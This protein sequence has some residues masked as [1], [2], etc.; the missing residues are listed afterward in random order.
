MAH[1]QEV[2]ALVYGQRAQAADLI[3]QIALAFKFQRFT[4]CELCLF[5]FHAM[6][7]PALRLPRD[8]AAGPPLSYW[9]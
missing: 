3:E 6:S 2:R 8:P 1:P 7:F 5:G 4:F 9:R